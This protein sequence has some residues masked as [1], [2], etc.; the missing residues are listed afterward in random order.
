[1]GLMH[2]KVYISFYMPAM[3]TPHLSRGVNLLL[4]G[5]L[6]KPSENRQLAVPA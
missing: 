4:P 5:E 6:I 3:L 2:A 1:M